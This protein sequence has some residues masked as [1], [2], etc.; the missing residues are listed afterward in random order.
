M[1]EVI[2]ICPVDDMGRNS[3]RPSTMAMM[4]ASAV[5]MYISCFVRK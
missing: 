4:M 5:L 3:V 2:T 1:E